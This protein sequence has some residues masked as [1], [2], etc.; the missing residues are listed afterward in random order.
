MRNMNIHKHVLEHGEE[1]TYCSCEQGVEVRRNIN[2][3]C[4]KSKYPCM[5]SKGGELFMF[6]Y[7]DEMRKSNLS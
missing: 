3:K 6:S 7:D 4:D 2:K 1:C 5:K